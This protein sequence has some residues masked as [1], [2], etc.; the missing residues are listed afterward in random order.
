MGKKYHTVGTVPQFN[1]KMVEMGKINTPNRHIH[2]RSLSWLETGTSILSGGVKKCSGR[3]PPFL[4]KLNHT[5][6]WSL[7]IVGNL[8][9]KT[10]KKPI[11]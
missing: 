6:T 9:I 2:D 4:V 10:L 7:F 5:Y 11:Y 8:Y 1:A 3:E